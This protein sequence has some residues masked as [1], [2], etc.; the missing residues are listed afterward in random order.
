MKYC[1]LF[2]SLIMWTG[3][4]A[5]D[6]AVSGTVKD[7][8]RNRPLKGVKVS[9]SKN[10]EQVSAV[11]EVYTDKRGCYSIPSVDR[12]AVLMF[13]NDK[14]LL[15]LVKLG[16]AEVL[17]SECRLDVVLEQDPLYFR[18]STDISYFFVF[19]YMPPSI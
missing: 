19:N 12:N 10:I 2:L 9:Y 15:K 13:S 17:T 14:Y 6:I 11:K 7:L 16:D 1:F 8:S 5:E 4:A 3:L 18:I